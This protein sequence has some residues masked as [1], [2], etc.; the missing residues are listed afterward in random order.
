MSTPAQ[1]IDFDSD[2]GFDH[3]QPLTH[4]SGTNVPKGS[5]KENEGMSN[6]KPLIY[7]TRAKP[8]EEIRL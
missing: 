6:I 4:A 5:D 8:V 1:T 7:R 2:G 3:Q